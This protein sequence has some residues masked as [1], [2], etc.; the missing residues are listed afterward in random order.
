MPNVIILGIAQFFTA[1]GQVTVVALGGLIGASLA[2]DPRLATLPVSCAVLGVALATLP[3]ALAMPRF[4]RQRVFIGGALF[5][6]CGAVAAAVAIALQSFTAYCIASV[7]LGTN[8]AFTA[9]YRFAAAES[10]GP[11]LVSRVI[12]WVMLGTIVAASFGPT[13]VVNVRDWAGTEY[14]ASFLLIACTYSLAALTLLLFRNPSVVQHQADEPARPLRAIARQPAF[15]MAVS[16]AA[17]GYGIMALIMTA[18]PLSM[19]VTDGHSVEA[20]TGVIQGHFLAMYAPS[21]FSGWLVARLGVVR[22][23][24][25]G[26]LLE[27]ACLG[28][29]WNLLFVASTTLLTQ[30]Y[31]PAERFR[32]Q[33]CNDFIMFGVMAM[34][35]LLAGVLINTTGWETMNLLALLPLVLIIVAGGWLTRQPALLEPVTAR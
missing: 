26:A 13:L 27:A 33:A 15:L 11:E 24:V 30:T 31:R 5:V 17:I 32:V 21:L 9:Q 34:A 28:V 7:M 3:A 18:T 10:V 6:T 16:G 2:P 22:M 29:G 35:S 19:H 20:T 23:L 25:L 14:V 4:G 1:I 8:L 12:A